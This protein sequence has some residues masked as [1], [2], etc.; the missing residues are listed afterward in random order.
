[1]K[2]EETR[3]EDVPGSPVPSPYS[4]SGG[5]EGFIAWGL[6]WLLAPVVFEIIDVAKS[7]ISKAT[8]PL[9]RN[10]RKSR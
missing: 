8:R 1:M 7:L 2:E 5:P 9:R 6:S 4:P 10:N 3:D